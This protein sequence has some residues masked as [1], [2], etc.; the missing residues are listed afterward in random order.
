LSRPKRW[1]YDGGPRETTIEPP[2]IPVES[3]VTL[4]RAFLAQHLLRGIAHEL[5]NQLQ[6]LTLGVGGAGGS[7]AS[8][9]ADL[10]ARIDEAIDA[11]TVRLDLLGRLG[12]MEPSPGRAGG[13]ATTLAELPRLADLM[14]N[15][16]EGRVE[17][18][19]I[20]AGIL[21]ATPP[22]V[23][24]EVLLTAVIA[25]RA[26]SRDPTRL[27][28]SIG[29]RLGSQIELHIEGDRGIELGPIERA[30]MTSQLDR[31]GASLREEPP[32]RVVLVLP[33]SD[34]G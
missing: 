17:V 24:R 2:P 22:S 5:R 32:R 33:L 19:A 3:L 34:P 29:P 16:P 15:L 8:T 9:P 6:V 7:E 11:M 14:R 28:I 12:R 21:V 23:V 30:V 13:L 10:R 26:G 18:A 31:F 20:P 25:A 4:H 27:L 1:H